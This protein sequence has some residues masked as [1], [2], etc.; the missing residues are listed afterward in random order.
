MSAGSLSSFNPTILSQLGWNERRAQVMTIPVWIVGVVGSLV[1]TLL[2]GRLNMR[3]PFVLPAILFSILGW[4][5]HLQQVDPPAVRYFA[6]FAISL[7]TFVQMPLYAGMLTA[8]LR[9]RAAT[10]FGTA[11]L[12][13]FGNCAN[14]VSSNVFISTQS[15]SYPVG[16]GMGLAITLLALPTMLLTMAAFVVHNR[17]I[18]KKI[19]NLSVG[20]KLDDQVDYKYVY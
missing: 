4:V 12:L 10:S 8:N 17:R 9:G 11:I 1:A 20:E 19:S 15:P 7:G 5:L 6:Q 18:D 2:S 3:W 13:G 14:L 16:F